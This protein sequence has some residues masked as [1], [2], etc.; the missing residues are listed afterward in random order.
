MLADDPSDS[1]SSQFLN[2]VP[3]TT[4]SFTVSPPHSSHHGHLIT[5][6]YAPSIIPIVSTPLSFQLT[7]S[8]LTPQPSLSRISGLC[9][10]LY[11]STVYS[12]HIRQNDLEYNVL[13]PRSNPIN[14]QFKILHQLTITQGEMPKSSPWLTTS[15]PLIIHSMYTYD[16][17]NKCLECYIPKY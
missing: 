13:K 11:P 16:Y 9:F 12:L 8:F 5:S 2:L 4:L 15:Q 17:V 14:P 1:L 6:K 7:P 10:G 3:P